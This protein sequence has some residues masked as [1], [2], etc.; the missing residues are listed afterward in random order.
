MQME[1]ASPYQIMG[2]NMTRFPVTSLAKIM[3]DLGHDWVDVLKIDIEG[4]EWAV[5]KALLKTGAVLPFTQLQ[6][7]ACHLWPLHTWRDDGKGSSVERLPLAVHGALHKCWTLTCRCPVPDRVS[8]LPLCSDTSQHHVGGAEGAGG[9]ECEGIPHRGNG[10]L[11][12]PLMLHATS[13]TQGPP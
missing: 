12:L 6:V 5:L 2:R 8:L 9:E 7:R 11:I 1:V 13:I 4:A 3:A 10:E